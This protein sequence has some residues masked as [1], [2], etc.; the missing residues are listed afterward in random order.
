MVD[1]DGVYAYSE[2]KVLKVR[3]SGNLSVYPNPVARELYIMLPVDFQQQRITIEISN[4]K[5]QLAL[6][7]DIPISSQIEIV[8]VI[9]LPKGIYLVRITNGKEQLIHKII[10]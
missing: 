7:R 10:K 6:K 1:L 5:G 8:P 9:Q 3:T 4:Q 2:T